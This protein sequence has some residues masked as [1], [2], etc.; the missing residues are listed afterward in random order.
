M[1]LL[2][3]L[4]YCLAVLMFPLSSYAQSQEKEEPEDSIVTLIS[5]KKAQLLEIDGQNLR[6]VTGP[7]TFL[8]NNTYLLC[9]TALWNVD[10][11]IIDAIGNVK[12]IQ[13][14]TELQ[15]EKM[16][17][18][19]DR[20]LAEF[21]G[22]VVQLR[23][24]DNNIL[25][26][27]NL[28]YNTKDSIAVFRGGG[29][30][31]DKDGQIIE[32]ETGK[33][34]SKIKL[35][36]FT[37][38]VNM[39]TDSIFVKTSRLM[40]ES[41]KNLATFGFGTDAW[42]DEN[43][44]SANAGWYDRGKEVF[45]FRNRVHVMSDV[46]EGWSDSLYFYRNSMDVEMLGNAQVTD[47]T[48][49]VSGLAGRISYTDS[50][51][52][53]TM[54]RKPAVVAEVEDT[55]AGR[56]TVYFGADTLI[57][58]TVRM[59]DVD[60]MVVADAGTRIS[61]MDVDPVTEFR[62]KAAEE[63]AKAAEEA[64][65]N[66]PNR[67]PDIPPEKGNEKQSPEKGKKTGTT[68]ALSASLPAGE[69]SLPTRSDSLS[70]AG[71]SLS[72]MADSLH[73]GSD[74]LAVGLDSLSAGPDS[75]SVGLD[76][77]SAGADSLASADST[78][79]PPIE[80]DTTKIGFVRAL[81]NVKIYRRDMQIV[82]DSLEYCDLDSIA[83]LFKQPMI[84]NEVTQQY[85][86]DSV[87]ALVRGNR[88]DKVS[89]MSNAFVHNQQDSVHYDQIRSTE[90]MAYFDENSQLSRFDALG[91]ASALFYLEENDALAT[92][93][94][95]ETKML[96]AVF[97][98]GNINRIYYFDTAKSDAYPVA[99]M[100]AE[101]QMLKGFCWQ[102]EKRPADRNAVTAQ[103]LRSSERRYYSSRPRAN[104]VRTGQYFPG[105]IDD[106]YT[107]IHQRDSLGKVRERQ[108]Q[109]MEQ[110]RRMREQF[111]KDSLA[112]A[113]LDSIAVA[114][115]I[116]RSD[117]LAFAADSIAKADS[118]AFAD[119]VRQ[120]EIADSLASVVPTKEQLR[121]QAR[122]ARE[123][124][125][126]AR[127]AAKEQRWAEKDQADADRLKAKEEKKKEKERARKLKLILKVQEEARKDSLELEK[128]KDRYR[129]MAEKRK[130]REERRS[131]RRKIKP[132]P[133]PETG[134]AVIEPDKNEEEL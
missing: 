49:N 84:W 2:K 4:A 5:S 48:R 91:G 22:N 42:K 114:D 19:I 123:E 87:Y 129:V 125:K 41:D 10:T 27:R 14:E 76:S 44:L 61:S 63:A 77:L 25:R 78:M 58:Y 52:R 15:S 112:I 86:A 66:D 99:Q 12:I 65:R 85:V 98:D 83:R 89:L 39:F 62:K 3:R 16:V 59:C 18:Y 37:E 75:L 80:P 130:I 132:Q 82:C 111:I 31:K 110:D 81:N 7:A 74:S 60:S 113:R 127:I 50:V 53:V 68:P 105:Y 46:Q 64:A 128:Y 30:M 40:Y 108:R 67:R 134:A 121:E 96:S 36:T 38:N 116:A 90:M 20:D 13:E 79:A 34:E 45:F 97:K 104:F 122:K 101:E 9:D 24:K 73:A 133:L 33:Y 72:V 43:M 126:A 35:F 117:S 29:S 93:N 32:S 102:P 92:V 8:H 95:K 55:E 115:S 1:G 120:A 124:K 107:Q 57:Y 88:L 6:K 100:T 26:T 109:L 119:S 28:D 118:I 23:D 131:A 103:K 21:R 11:K 51:S 94:K 70:A 69:D 17:Y 47:T 56:D 54:T 106:I 71:D